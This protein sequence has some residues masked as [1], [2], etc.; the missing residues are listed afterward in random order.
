MSKRNAGINFNS[1]KFKCLVRYMILAAKQKRCVPY[2]E[3]ENCFGL[4]HK[5]V[6]YYA[7]ILGDYCI[8]EKL[9]RLNGLI[10]SSTDCRPSKGFNWYQKEYGKSWGELVTNCWKWFHVVSSRKKQVQDFS[11][12]DNE[13]DIFLAK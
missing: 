9:P 8:E 2:Y 12:L 13:I 6:G 11:G 3:L 4:S 10:I 5:Q 1:E 7:G